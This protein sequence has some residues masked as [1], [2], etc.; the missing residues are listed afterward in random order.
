MTR[1]P[2]SCLVFAH[3][4]LF[5]LWLGGDVGVYTLGRHFRMRA[6][7]SIEQRLALLKLLVAIDMV[8][9][10]AWALMVPVSLSVVAAGGYWAVPRWLLALAWIAGLL[11]TWLVWDAHAHERTPRAARERRVEFWL[12]I[13]LALFYLWLGSA[14]LA[15]G[16]PLTA[17]WLAVK[18]LAFG[19]IFG[20][21]TMIDVAYRPVGA[22]L[23]RLLREGSSDATELPLLV[24]MNR[25]RAWVW[26]VYLLLLVTAF[27]GVAKPF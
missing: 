8:P 14:S 26:T 3:L 10:T 15:T 13:V 21:A 4:L 9:R 11:W 19:L 2:Y 5:V 17:A 20:A 1:L 24:T 12:K 22:Q 23:G 7:Y 27:L 18:A 16:A 6:R 25:T